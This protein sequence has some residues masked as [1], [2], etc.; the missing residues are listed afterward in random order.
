MANKGSNRASATIH[1]TQGAET[2]I[3][4]FHAVGPKKITQLYIEPEKYLGYVFARHHRLRG[5]SK[6]NFTS[7]MFGLV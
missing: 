7:Y 4:F 6:T 2:L 3:A 5:E 1:T